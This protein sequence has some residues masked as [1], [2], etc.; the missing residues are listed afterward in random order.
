MDLSKFT[1]QDKFLM[2]ALDHRESFRRLMNP[3]NPTDVIDEEI[4][5]V[6][7]EIIKS[8]VGQFSAI[9]LDFNYGLPAYK[10]KLKPF[11]LALEKTGYKEYD[12]ERYTEIELIGCEI[13]EYRASGCK[14]LIYFNPFYTSAQ[15]QMDTV[16]GILEDLSEYDLPLFLEIVTYNKVEDNHKK[17][18]L[19]IK[20]IEVF[21]KN[22]IRPDVFKL[23]YPGE[24]E[25]CK[26][27]T[28]IL[29]DTPWILL[30]GGGDFETF[31]ENLRVAAENGASGFLA[32]RALWQEIFQYKGEQ[33]KQFLMEVL[34]NRFK[35]LSEIC[36]S[37][38]Y[39]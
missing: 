12:N 16:Y 4:V 35:E 9:L 29:G 7:S 33:R 17:S 39:G 6:K 15:S 2:L 23:E 27:I 5:Q 31:K 24:A 19:I 38:K 8:L 11:I 34:P 26:K 21:L 36:L 30:T 25:T 14:V 18:D 22:D 1:F 10:N 32:G 13:E 20:S 3:R 28:E 37:K